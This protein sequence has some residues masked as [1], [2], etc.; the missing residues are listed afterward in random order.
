M[1]ADSWRQIPEEAAWLKPRENW[2]PK[3][4][5][6][7]RSFLENQAKWDTPETNRGRNSWFKHWSPRFFVAMNHEILATDVAI[8]GWKTTI[9]PLL[10]RLTGA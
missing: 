8:S 3:L 7:L 1:Y 5:W 4:V 10:T 9:V 6:V 2:D